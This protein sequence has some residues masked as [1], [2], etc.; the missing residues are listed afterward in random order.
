MRSLIVALS[1]VA[2]T[3]TVA[4]SSE[5]HPVTPCRYIDTRIEGC[6]IGGGCHEGPFVDGETRT[7]MMQ[8]SAVCPMTSAWEHPI[9][10]GAQVLVVTITAIEPTNMGHL[11]AFDNS[12]WEHPRI[13]TLNFQPSR[14]TSGLAFISLAPDPGPGVPLQPDMAVYTRVAK[15]G[16]VHVTIDIVGYFK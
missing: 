16:S 14:A 3:A 6:V 13:S 2:L 4:E 10:V 9:P 1:I 11:K 7:Y 5:F 12:L 8:G 15:G